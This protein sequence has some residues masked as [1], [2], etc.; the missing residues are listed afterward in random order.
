MNV[1]VI[2]TGY[3]GI[4][5]GVCLASKGHT[6]TCVDIDHAKVDK[7]NGGIPPI[8]EIGL[9]N[10]LKSTV[11]K[12]MFATT[13]LRAAVLGS[14]LTLIAVGTPFDGNK[15][16]LSFVREVSKQIGEV[17]REKQS[18]HVVVV[19]STVVPGTTDQVVLPILEA[20]SGKKAGE[21]FGVG[22]NPEFLTEGQAIQDF[23]NPDR[24]VLGG[25]DERSTEV[26]EKLYESFDRVLK[27]RTNTRT[28]EMIKYTS[29]AL[30]ATLISFSNEI[31]NLGSAL[32]GIDA[33]DVMKGVQASYYLS[34]P[35]EN[36]ERAKAP[37]TS[38]LFAGCG[39]GGSCLPKDVNALIAHGRQ[40]GVP[41]PLLQAVI[42]TNEQ[43]PNQI[44][45]LLRREF[46]DVAGV[47]VGVLGLAFKSDTDDMRESPA[48]PIIRS[49]LSLKAVIKAYDPIAMP[50]AQRILGNDT[51]EYV[52]T[53]Q[54]CLTGVDVVILVTSWKEFE[55]V[56]QLLKSIRP[57][58]LV[59][60]GRRLLDK[61]AVDRYAGIG[62]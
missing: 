7:I 5:S 42:K 1:S 26:L 54:D 11:G 47:R 12:N 22:M 43:Q 60:D 59:I 16:D 46:P 38:F 34:M 23:M 9:E 30:L 13:D 40:I 31:A 15:I 24:I 41:M 35:G 62:L 58:P 29:N 20:A 52:R 19:K 37:I 49:L 57:Q 4:V 18:Y 50:E 53:L 61:R 10:L 44:L 45:T 27:I 28:A 39:F 2:G 25:I 51:I 14:E 55:N 17:L 33:V 8:Y 6:V 48:I 36:Q 56:P 32:G 3:V 21:N